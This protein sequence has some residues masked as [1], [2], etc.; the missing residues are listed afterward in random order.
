[1]ALRDALGTAVRAAHDGAAAE[2]IPVSMVL[3][4]TT[5]PEGLVYE[6]RELFDLA[7]HGYGEVADARGGTPP[8]QGCVNVERF[9]D[10]RSHTGRF[11][12]SAVVDVVLEADA[13]TL[14]VRELAY[15]PARAPLAEQW[16]PRLTALLLRDRPVLRYV[17]VD[18][19]SAEVDEL[20]FVA[21]D[22]PG[23]G[24]Q[25]QRLLLP[26]L[27]DP[28]RAP[29]PTA[30]PWCASCPVRD[31]CPAVARTPVTAVLEGEPR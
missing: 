23:L 7:V 16:R 22:L 15:T 3:D 29:E 24:G 25:L 20:D 9:Y 13:D 21:E 4:G 2:G 5:P 1:M 17:R 19:L 10:Q 31:R 12:L 18:V 11:E 30:G 14:E 27:D 8:P 26:L 6:Q 28:D